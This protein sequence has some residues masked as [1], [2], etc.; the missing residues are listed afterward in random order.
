MCRNYIPPEVDEII[1]DAIQ[2]GI[3]KLGIALHLEKNELEQLSTVIPELIEFPI[4]LK[5]KGISLLEKKIQ[6][7]VGTY[8]FIAMQKIAKQLQES[9]EYLLH[10]IQVLL[11][12]DFF[13][14]MGHFA[15]DFHL[16]IPQITEDSQ[17]GLQGSH[18]NNLDLMMA[19][20]QG[21]LNAIPIDYQIGT[22]GDVQIPKAYLNL[23]TGSNSGGKTV[24]L[25]TIF[26]TVLLAQMGIPTLGETVFFPSKNYISL[27]NQQANSPQAPLKPHYY[28]LWNYL[29]CLN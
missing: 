28:N 8:N 27:K 24:C 6:S 23:L 12:F 7:R 20:K 1:N 14:G 11:D 2:N 4:N 22:I 5:P 29:I 18:M 19:E 10:L 21:E 25:T 3:T 26:Q 16:S 17:F 9:Y 13:Y 15:N